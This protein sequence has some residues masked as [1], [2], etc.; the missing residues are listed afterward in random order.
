MANFEDMLAYASDS[1]QTST[2]PRRYTYK[3]GVKVLYM[4]ENN[5]NGVKKIFFRLLPARRTDV[6]DPQ[7]FLVSW[8]PSI[9]PDGKL[10]QIGCFLHSAKFCGRGDFKNRREIVSRKTLGKGTRC[11]YD[12]LCNFIEQNKSDWG[13]L[14]ED[15]GK[16]R[17]P[18]YVKAP[19]SKI[20]PRLLANVIDMYDQTATVKIGEF[21][22]TAWRSL[23]SRGDKPGLMF[24]KNNAVPPEWL[25]KDYMYQ[26]ANGDLTNPETGL[27]LEVSRDDSATASFQGYTV[28]TAKTPDG[29]PWR[30]SVSQQ[31]LAARYDLRDVTNIVNVPEEQELVD[32][33][34]EI[35]NQ[36]SPKGYHERALLKMAFADYGW[37]VPE[38][39]S[40]PAATQTVPVAPQPA[41]VVQQPAPVPKPAPVVQQPAA[42]PAYVPRPDVQPVAQTQPPQAFNTTQPQISGFVPSPGYRGVP[43]ETPQ[44]SRDEIVARLKGAN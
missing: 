39:T 44:M 14:F 23:M 8:S 10:T 38:P 15:V 20:Q 5:K 41:P 1:A 33:L 26:Y 3:E 40:A 31:Q 43:G 18:G 24:I 36:R 12:I 28:T 21:S 22:Q 6:Q 34:V 13:Y 17:Q 25:Q 35:L 16:F 29:N 9:L 19:L 42:V 27:V 37:S 30:Q 11:P 2:A 4:Q 7:A 32:E